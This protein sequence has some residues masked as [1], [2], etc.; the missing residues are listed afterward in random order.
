M[1]I[2]KYGFTKLYNM[3][4]HVT[5]SRT[6]IKYKFIHMINAVGEL[7]KICFSAVALNFIFM[8]R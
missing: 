4:P 1:A 8:L 3:N 2:Y 7:F 6:K 5:L